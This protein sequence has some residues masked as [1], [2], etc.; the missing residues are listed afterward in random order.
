MSAIVQNTQYGDLQCTVVDQLKGAAPRLLVVL[1]H[2]FGAPGTDLVPLAYEF[3][4]ASPKIAGSVRFIFPQAPVD[5]TPAGMPGGR[6][7]WLINMEKLATVFQTR[8]YSQLTE[9]EPPGL[10]DASAGLSQAVQAMLEDAGLTGEQ[11]FLGGFSQGAMVSTDVVLRSGLCP[12]LLILMSGTLLCR[13]D[14]TKLADEHRGCRVIQT[15]GNADTVLPIEP[16]TWLR[17]LLSEHGFN[18]EYAA[19]TG[20]HTVP[21]IA[22]QMAAQA[23]IEKLEDLP[24]DPPQN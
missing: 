23:M 1:S 17:D 13:A 21:P 2:G 8:D 24:T 22:L 14:W 20:P 9:V 6:A 16:S 15:H 3:L 19:F 7:W 5:L 4:N 11:L 18:V 10:R 12:A